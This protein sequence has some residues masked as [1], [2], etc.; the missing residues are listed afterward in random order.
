MKA[1]EYFEYRKNNNRY[2]IGKQL[3]KQVIEKV[4]PTIIGVLYLEY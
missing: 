2:L 4:L 1:V 3:L